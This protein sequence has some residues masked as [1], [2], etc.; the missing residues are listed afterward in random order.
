MNDAI[1][2]ELLRARQSRTP[3]AL[4]TVAATTGSVPRQPGSKMLVYADGK[5]SGTIGGGKFE[6][7]VVE[8]SIKSIA[9]K[10]TLLKTYPL[11]E[12]KPDSFGAICGGE[13]TIMIEPQNLSAALFL[14]GAGHCSLAIAK[15]ATDCGMYVTVVED[16]A[17]LIENFPPPTNRVVANSAKFI[18]QRDWSDDEALV[19][20]SRNYEL[21]R[22]ALAA[23]LKKSGAGYIG[24]IGSRR[25]VHRV[26]DALKQA[27]SVE[28]LKDIYAPIG[29]DIGADSPA[30]IAVSVIG[31][32]LQVLR[33]RKGGHLRSAS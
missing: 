33:K 1:L 14:V 10:K 27:V 32:I 29:L 18:S 5:T 21:D 9:A 8:E 25:K 7:L 26:F 6:A 19:L 2:E 15:L 12:D 4:A 13:V 11:R 30:E 17:E 23:A 16:R 22:E 20:V 3:C 31:E 24:M 28:K